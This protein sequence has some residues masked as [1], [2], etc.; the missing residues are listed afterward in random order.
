M[1]K[2]LE[3]GTTCTG[4]CTFESNLTKAW[5]RA[6]AGDFGDKDLEMALQQAGE[7]KR[8][9]ALVTFGHMHQALQPRWDID[10]NTKEGGLRNMADI[11][12][13]SGELG[14]HSNQEAQCTTTSSNHT[15]EHTRK[16]AG[17]FSI[18]VSRRRSLMLKEH[19]AETKIHALI[20]V[21]DLE[22]AL[23]PARY[24]L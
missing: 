3:T 4:Y 8:D 11:D 18:P 15:Y 1:R 16:A 10:T 23:Y 9:I 7:R 5:Y 20:N 17:Q 22:Q 24:G 6:N 21:R 14:L 19:A 2:I 13:E 12:E